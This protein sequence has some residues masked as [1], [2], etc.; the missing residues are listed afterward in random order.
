MDE[1]NHKRHE[2]PD[3]IQQHA[4]HYLASKVSALGH[5]WAAPEAG[6]QETSLHLV[7]RDCSS[8]SKK[9]DRHSS[10]VLDAEPSPTCQAPFA[11]TC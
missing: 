11:Q 7:D 6:Q 8:S 4:S 2:V 10:A 9:G 3:G 5:S 1:D